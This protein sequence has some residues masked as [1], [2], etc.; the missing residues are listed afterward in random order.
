MYVASIRLDF[1]WELS[2]P[3]RLPLGIPIKSKNRKRGGRPRAL[4]FSLSPALPAIQRGLCGGASS[5]NE[6]N[7]Q[8]AIWSR[9]FRP[10]S[11][12]KL[13]TRVLTICQVKL[14]QKHNVWAKEFDCVWTSDRFLPS[15]LLTLTL[16]FF[17]CKLSEVLR[18]HIYSPLSFSPTL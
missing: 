13:I 6:L 1:R 18:A 12:S 5:K 11:P 2:P 17:S 4:S 8:N 14:T 10:S 3:H 7:E 9:S 16:T 15:L